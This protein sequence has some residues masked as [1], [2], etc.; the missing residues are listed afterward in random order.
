MNIT[1]KGGDLHP[2]TLMKTIAIDY[3]VHFVCPKFVEEA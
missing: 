3:T 2:L 1:I